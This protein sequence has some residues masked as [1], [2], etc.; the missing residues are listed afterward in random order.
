MCNYFQQWKKIH[1]LA[2][3][4]NTNTTI[5]SVEDSNDLLIYFLCVLKEN[6]LAMFENAYHIH[7]VIK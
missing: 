1:Y 6:I 2:N 3:G 7:W 4:L 5:L